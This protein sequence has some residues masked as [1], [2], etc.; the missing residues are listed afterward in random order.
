MQRIPFLN[1]ARTWPEWWLD[2]AVVAVVVA[3][4]AALTAIS[5]LILAGAAVGVQA[6]AALRLWSPG[7][8]G[9]A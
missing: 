3:V 1:P 8:R 9:D 7:G 2:S 6:G 4:L 5:P